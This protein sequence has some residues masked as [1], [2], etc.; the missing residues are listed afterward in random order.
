MKTKMYCEGGEKREEK[1]SHKRR[2]VQ[3][4]PSQKQSGYLHDQQILRM[5]GHTQ[6][7]GQADNQ[8]QDQ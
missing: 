5:L 7:H 8:I 1:N 3:R 6:A 2:T 4:I